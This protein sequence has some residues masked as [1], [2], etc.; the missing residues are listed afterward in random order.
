L[1]P[2]TH[3]STCHAHFVACLAPVR[4]HPDQL[5]CRGLM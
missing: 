2:L 4:F 3:K 5:L 1:Y